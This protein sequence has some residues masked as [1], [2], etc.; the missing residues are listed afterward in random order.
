M[1]I[2][3]WAPLERPTRAQRFRRA[4]V[5]RA[6]PRVIGSNRDRT[7]LFYDILLPLLGTISFVYVYRA[8]GAPERFVGYVIMGGAATAFWMNVMWNM[9]GQFFWDKQGGNM[10]H[11][12]MMPCGIAS[13]LIGMSVGGLLATLVRA[14]AIVGLG[15]LLFGVRFSVSQ[16]PLFVAV[17]LVASVALYGLG[18]TFA[19]LFLFWGR[20]AWHMANLFM[21]P[22]FLGSGFYFPVRALGAAAWVSA[23]VVPI[24]LGLDAM[25]GL[26]FS[27]LHPLL[28]PVEVE[29]AI[30]G[31]LAVAFSL[32]ARGMLRRMERLSRREGRL[33]LRF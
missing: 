22:V 14:V 13:I 30:L 8:L 7:W 28:A 20:E 32:L 17:F 24:T 27:D 5:G 16:W 23:S 11:Y 29:L 2:A 26:L 10:E 15:S 25:R 12:M 9:A 6:Y 21:E 4:V 18:M 31:G 3:A 33:G 1:S 19:S